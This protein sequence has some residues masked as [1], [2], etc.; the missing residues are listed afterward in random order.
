MII[1]NSRIGDGMVSYQ[2][3]TPIRAKQLGHGALS[4]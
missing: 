3:R 2:V 4:Q 1:F